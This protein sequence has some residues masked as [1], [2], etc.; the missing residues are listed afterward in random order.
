MVSPNSGSIALFF[1]F[2]CLLLIGLQGKFDAE[3][4]IKQLQSNDRSRHKRY[5]SQATEWGWDA[6]S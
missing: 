2:F 5:H 6:A 3:G 1:F 4:P